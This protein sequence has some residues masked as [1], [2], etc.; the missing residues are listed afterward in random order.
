MKQLLG[1]FL[2]ITYA[3]DHYF[4]NVNKNREQIYF[5]YNNEIPEETK[6]KYYIDGIYLD[7][8]SEALGIKVSEAGE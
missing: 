7:F 8:A 3:D 1:D 5:G 2:D 4:I 6:V